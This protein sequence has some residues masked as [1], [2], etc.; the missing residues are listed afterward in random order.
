MVDCLTTMFVVLDLF[1]SLVWVVLVL[2]VVDWLIW[3]TLVVL[4]FVLRFGLLA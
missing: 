3:I 1:V 2:I 4:R